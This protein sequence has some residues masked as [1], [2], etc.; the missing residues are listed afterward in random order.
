MLK[1]V[2]QIFLLK[3]E[4]THL[5]IYNIERQ[6]RFISTTKHQYGVN[7]DKKHVKNDV[8]NFVV[9]TVEHRFNNK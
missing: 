5:T 6:E 1:T 7:N 2:F 4:D 8:S 9:N 3:G